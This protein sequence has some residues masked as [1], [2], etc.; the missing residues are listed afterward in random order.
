LGPNLQLPV[1]DDGSISQDLAAGDLMLCTWFNTTETVDELESPDDETADDSESESGSGRE[2]ATL[3]LILRSCPEGYNPDSAKA[4]PEE[5]CTTFVD[6]VNISA[7][8][9]EIKKRRQTGETDPGVATYD[10][11]PSGTYRLH[12]GNPDGVSRGFIWSCESSERELEPLF[13]PTARIDETGSIKITLEAPETITCLWYNLPDSDEDDDVSGDQE[14]QSNGSD[15]SESDTGSSGGNV[16]ITVLDCPAVPNPASCKPALTEGEI[17]LVP[18][19]GGASIVVPSLMDG[20]ARLELEPGVYQLKSD[21]Q[22]CFVQSES[23]NDEG[24]LTVG[25]PDPIAV[26]VFVCAR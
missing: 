16:L 21:P 2:T 10:R 23:I 24:L 19:N 18:E 22:P 9:S 6:D 15:I 8:S 20:S 26:T 4:D 12:Q 25:G 14:D 3:I 11:L 7:T 5:D 13:T 1:A 17:E